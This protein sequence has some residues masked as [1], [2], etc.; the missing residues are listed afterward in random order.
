MY[1]FQLQGP[2]EGLRVFS[3]SKSWVRLFYF[4]AAYKNADVFFLVG[5]IGE[6]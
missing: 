5:K 4:L 3:K 6:L 1:G 2:K